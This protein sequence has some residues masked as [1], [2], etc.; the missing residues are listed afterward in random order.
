MGLLGRWLAV[1]AVHAGVRPGIGQV[2]DDFHA[3]AFRAHGD[4]FPDILPHRNSVHPAFVVHRED[5][6]GRLLPASGGLRKSS[7]IEAAD[8]RWNV[9]RMGPK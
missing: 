3:D 9:K 8:A 1:A 6:V 7:S 5:P 2:G 4:L